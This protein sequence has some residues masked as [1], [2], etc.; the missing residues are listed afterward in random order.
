[1]IR[2]IEL[3]IRSLILGVAT[4]DDFKKL[5]SEGRRIETVW[6]LTFGDYPRLFNEAFW[7]KLCVV[8]DRKLVVQWLDEIRLIRNVV[9][10]F[11]PDGL[12]P[13]RLNRLRSTSAFLLGLQPMRRSATPP[14]KDAC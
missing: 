12:D 7:D 14:L 3:H 13:D 8:A 9:M 1:M 11:D 4:E 2:D 10:H 5:E 6:D